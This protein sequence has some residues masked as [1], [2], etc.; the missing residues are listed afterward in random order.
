M[1]YTLQALIGP[2]SA[3]V[4]HKSD[5]R[6]THLVSLNQGFAMILVTPELYDELQAAN[7][8]AVTTNLDFSRFYLL[9]SAV[10]AWAEQLSING[11]MAYI[12]ADFWGGVG[13]QN[14]V[15]WKRGQLSLKPIST[16]VG[17]D[18]A[19]FTFTGPPLRE[20]AINQALRF[21]GVVSEPDDLDEF[22]AVGLRKH[23]QTED[24]IEE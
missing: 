5:F 14:A 4:P 6:E 8:S 10:T 18:K 11:P 12:E 20:W 7:L 24:W 2:A 13:S 9:S 17:W 1:G 15:G 23:R 19:N 21:I 22:E 3:L 16:E